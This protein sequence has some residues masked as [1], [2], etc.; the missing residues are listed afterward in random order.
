M[1]LND[2]IILLQ[3]GE[4]LDELNKPIKTW[5]PFLPGDG[6]LW[7]SVKDI[8]GRQFVAAGG[9]QN[10]VQTEIT[11]RRRA[12]LLPGMRVRKGVAIYE[13]QAILERGRDWT[14]LMCK[15]GVADG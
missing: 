14:V 2:R 11:I 4:A 8:S 10:P 5:S 6:G 3:L 1:S 15:K 13:I 7:A 9:V 12:D